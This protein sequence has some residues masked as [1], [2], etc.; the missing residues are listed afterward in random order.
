MILVAD[1]WVVQENVKKGNT[2]YVLQALLLF[3]KL[4]GGHSL[5]FVEKAVPIEGFP[6]YHLLEDRFCLRSN[7]EHLSW[8]I[9][10]IPSYFIIARGILWYVSQKVRKGATR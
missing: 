8:W 5:L 1:I 6:K 9:I 10:L 3:L 4:A 2:M 7:M